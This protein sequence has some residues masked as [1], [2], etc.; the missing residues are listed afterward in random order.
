MTNPWNL[1]CPP[2]PRAPWHVEEASPGS[3]NGALLVRDA[4]LRL[5]VYKPTARKRRL[6]DFPSGTLARREV[7]ACLLSQ[8][9]GIGLV[10]VTVLVG[11][12]HKDLARC[13]VG[14]TTTLRALWFVST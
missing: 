13:S 11:D 7:A 8:V 12:G 5:W 3:S 9:M 2:G 1:P 10:P 14:S 6:H 4:D